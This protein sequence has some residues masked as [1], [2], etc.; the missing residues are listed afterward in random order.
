MRRVRATLPRGGAT[1]D[2][3]ASGGA[4]ADEGAGDGEAA[5]GGETASPVEEGS[6][7]A[8]AAADAISLVATRRARVARHMRDRG[9][10][11]GACPEM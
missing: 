4:T 2:D 7:V 1:A 5:G 3:G 6:W 10:G 8:I 9:R 11:A